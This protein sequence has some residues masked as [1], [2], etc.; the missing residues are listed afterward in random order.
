MLLGFGLP[1]AFALLIQ[2]V[3]YGRSHTNPP[4]GPEPSWDSPRTLELARRACF[5][6]HSGETDWPWYA[7]VA[8]LSWRIQTH[9]DQGRAA[10]DFTDFRPERRRVARSAGDAGRAVETLRMPP[11]DYAWMHTDAR[12][13]AED[14]RELAAGLDSTFAEFVRERWA[15]SR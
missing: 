13:N 3:P 4:R 14:R 10:L 8:P 11:N 15:G 12:L 9:V 2:L 6:C 5:D 7:S 1:V